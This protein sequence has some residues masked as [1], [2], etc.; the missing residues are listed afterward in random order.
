MAERMFWSLWLKE[1][2]LNNVVCTKQFLLCVRHFRK[3]L[4]RSHDAVNTDVR[5]ILFYLCSFVCIF[6]LNP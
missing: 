5:I 3:L 6:V 4:N 1:D 2:M